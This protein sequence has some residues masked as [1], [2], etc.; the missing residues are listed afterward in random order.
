MAKALPPG[1]DKTVMKKSEQD[2]ETL[3]V[4]LKVAEGEIEAHLRAGKIP[5]PADYSEIDRIKAELKI[6]RRV[7]TMKARRTADGRE[8]LD[9]TISVS[10]SRISRDKLEAMAASKAMTLSEYLRWMIDGHID[11]QDV[12]LSIGFLPGGGKAS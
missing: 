7:S 8:Y 6:A 11:S 9:T 12:D 4:S 2:I 5:T 3:T 1:K 10:I